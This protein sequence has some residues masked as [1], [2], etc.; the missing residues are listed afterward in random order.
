MYEEN[1]CL[2]N[3]ECFPTIKAFPSWELQELCVRAQ[4]SSVTVKVRGTQIN[5][6][7]L[8]FTI[9]LQVAIIIVSNNVHVRSTST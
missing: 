5:V 8:I 3:L 2:Q 4:N 9:R 6:T 7:V 1:Q